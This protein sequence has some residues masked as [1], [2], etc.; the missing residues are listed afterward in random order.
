MTPEERQ[1]AV[2]AV[3]QYRTAARRM[4]RN[5]AST[6]AMAINQHVHNAH[7]SNADQMVRAY[8]TLRSLDLEHVARA[9]G[10][11]HEANQDIACARDEGNEVALAK[12]RD[13][14]NAAQ[15]IIRDALTEAT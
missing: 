9:L 10:D 7:A 12:A 14:L 5:G 3:V 4:R 13:R 2:R 15:H 8:K 11:A 1:E 6:F